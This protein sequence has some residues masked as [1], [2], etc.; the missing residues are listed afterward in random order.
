LLKKIAIIAG[1]EREVRPLV[2][3]WPSRK[4]HY[5]DREFTFY[6]GEHAVVVCGGIGQERAGS[7]AEAIIA[8]IA[9]ELVISAGVSGALVAELH[10]GDTI[11]PGMVIDTGDGSK[12]QTAISKA[13]VGS[14][15]L[16]RTVL[17]THTKI[18]G[19]AEKQWLAKAYRAHA[20]DMESAAV[21]RAAEGHSLPF[22][23][24]KSISDEL[25]FELPAMSQFIDQGD[26]QTARF[27]L[28]VALR[29][30]LWLRAVR[31]AQNTH[32]AA[33]NLCAWLRA[34]ALT[35]TIVPSTIEPRI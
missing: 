10:V 5:Q 29:P 13:P 14:T 18:A 20:V 4:V 24:V 28:H 31:L 33:L 15:A 26:F 35:N 12:Y 30:W 23:A 27:L 3:N 34:S 9:P 21:A 32:L 11:F 25:E 6:E 2:K 17:A 1:L 7:A 22:L 16:G 8:T 19:A